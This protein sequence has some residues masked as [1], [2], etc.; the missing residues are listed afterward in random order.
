MEVLNHDLSLLVDGIF[1]TFNVFAKLFLGFFRVKL[2]VA[3][4]LFDQ[5][6]VAVGEG[7][8]DEM[9]VDFSSI[10]FVSAT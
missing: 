5:F 9:I 1:V 8:C 7:V 10:I 4:D 6:I 3:F 2:R